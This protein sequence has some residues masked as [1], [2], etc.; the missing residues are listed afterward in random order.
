MKISRWISYAVIIPLA[1]TFWGCAGNIPES[2]RNQDVDNHWGE[3]FR[4]ARDSQILNPDAGK[5]VRPVFGMSGD[6]AE[7]AM[8]KLKGPAASSP[9]ST[10]TPAAMPAAP[11]AK[12]G[13]Y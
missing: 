5:I 10:G 7:T 8:D 1:L 9:G 4:Q 11:A 6:A 13:N 3:S 2:E 12:P